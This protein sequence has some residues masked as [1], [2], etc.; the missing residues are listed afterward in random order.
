MLI[1]NSFKINQGYGSFYKMKYERSFEHV[2]EKASDS[3]LS[4]SVA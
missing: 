1:K 4:S 3:V 2:V